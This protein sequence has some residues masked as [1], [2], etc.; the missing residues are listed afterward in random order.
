[1]TDLKDIFYQDMKQTQS[2]PPNK[3]RLALT[4]SKEIHDLL[5]L[6]SVENDCNIKQYIL[7]A[8]FEKV[9]REEEK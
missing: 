5:R 3:K 6:K 7:Q 1:M 4:I 8:V 9:T 2:N